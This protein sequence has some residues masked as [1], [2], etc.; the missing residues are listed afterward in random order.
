MNENK[1]IRVENLNKLGLTAIELSDR[2]GGRA[3]YWRGML[4]GT[5]PFGETVARKIESA[6]GKPRGSMDEY[7]GVTP[8]EAAPY[9][10]SGFALALAMM[11]DELPDDDAIRSTAWVNAQ[12]AIL[13]ARDPQNN[14]PAGTPAPSRSPKRLH[15]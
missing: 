4:A 7:Q 12:Q 14:L 3:T 15:G 9:K 6:L 10:P 1:L 5:R 8:A 13:S 2:V 11:Y